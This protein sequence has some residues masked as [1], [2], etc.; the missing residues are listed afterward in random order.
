MVTDEKISQHRP[1]IIAL[2][3]LATVYEQSKGIQVV[4]YLLNTELISL[5]DINKVSTHYKYMA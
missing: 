2:A 4:D 5:S 3:S 1:A